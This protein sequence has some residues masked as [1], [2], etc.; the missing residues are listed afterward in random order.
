MKKIHSG[1]KPYECSE[2][3]SLQPKAN[4]IIHQKVHTGEK[5]YDCN[6]CGKAFSL[7]LLPY[8]SSEKSHRGKAL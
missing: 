8:S 5:P 1:E 4:F 7:K 3:E 2:W 6:E